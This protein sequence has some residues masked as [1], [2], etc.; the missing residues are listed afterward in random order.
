MG[1]P[2]HETRW[3]LM[4]AIGLSPLFL[5]VLIWIIGGLMG[6]ARHGL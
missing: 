4:I 1:K 3:G 5:G 2:E 6:A